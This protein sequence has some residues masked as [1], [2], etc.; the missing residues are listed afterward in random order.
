[1]PNEPTPTDLLMARH[2]H[3]K[4]DAIVSKTYREFRKIIREYETL[5]ADEIFAIGVNLVMMTTVRP[6]EKMTT[7][8]A[9][10]RAEIAK[11]FALFI[12]RGTAETN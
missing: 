11:Q 4:V 1:M 5:S 2:A 10:L 8:P 6:L 3:R 9:L 12:E 7:N